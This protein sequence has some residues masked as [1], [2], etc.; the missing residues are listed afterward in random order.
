M[1]HAAGIASV[2]QENGTP[3]GLLPTP[4]GFPLSHRDTGKRLP[5]TVPVRGSEDLQLVAGIFARDTAAL[6]EVFDRDRAA[7]LGMLTRLLGRHGEAEEVLQEVFLWLW[8][9][10]KRYDPE[11]SSLRGWLF[12][13]ARSRALDVLR[14][15]KSRRLREDGVG[16]ET[17]TRVEDV[18]LAALEE[19][20]RRRRVAGALA[21]LPAEQRR[22]LELAF[23]GGLSHTEIAAQLEQPLGTVKSRIQLGMA[24]LRVTLAPLRETV[25]N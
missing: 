12:V 2:E 6:S 10:P 21:T 15:A 14:S 11:R 13:L 19:S 18:P 16:H 3:L 24:K 23:F 5:R 22:C 20:E 1:S 8:R 17:P 7:V 4:A 9:N 25:A